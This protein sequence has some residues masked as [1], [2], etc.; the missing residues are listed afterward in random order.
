MAGTDET[1]L[2]H[3]RQSYVDGSWTDVLEPRPLEVVD[4]SDETAFATITL[5][6]RADVD[7]AVA[8]ARRAFPAFARWTREQRL[9]LLRRT[10]AV[11]E[12]RAED[13]AQALSRE[14]GAPIAFARS[15]QAVMGT[16]HLRQTIAALEGF[17][18][19]AM[20]GTTRVVREPI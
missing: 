16:I 17:E 5:A 7:R 3:A 13:M 15:D 6:G 2:A 19:E 20:S 9:D 11:Y 8:A 18:L 1:V 4:P 12:R 10:L 14:M